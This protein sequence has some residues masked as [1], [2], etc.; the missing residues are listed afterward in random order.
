MA[1]NGH[2]LIQFAHPSKFIV[3]NKFNISNKFNIH[4]I[5]LDLIIVYVSLAKSVFLANATKHH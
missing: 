2:S 5:W 1:S 4:I 3:P